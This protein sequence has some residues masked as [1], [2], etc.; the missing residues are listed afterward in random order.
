MINTN[1]P[2]FITF[3][4]VEGS[5]KSTQS[6]MLYKYLLSKN[7]NAIYTREIGGT[8]E[9]EEIRTF[10]LHNNNIE[11]VTELMLIMAARFEHITKVI[12][13]ALDNNTWVICDRFIDS[14]ACYQGKNSH[15]TIDKVYQLHEEIMQGLMPDITFFINLEPCVA[16]QR[17]VQRGNNN[18]F[19]DKSIEFH[20]QIY[21]CLHK[22]AQQFPDRIKTVQAVNQTV[23]QIHNQ[24]I[25]ILCL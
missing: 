11:S 5:G 18:K 23:K 16:I 17:T 4:G 22:L 25:D 10:L 19:E 14:T 13:P 21:Q 20:K 1:K 2:K 9:A 8:E 3:E 24:I 12:L 6:K 7:I 15:I